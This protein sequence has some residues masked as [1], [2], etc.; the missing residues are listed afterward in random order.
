MA[1]GFMFWSAEVMVSR[2]KLTFSVSFR[3][4]T[5][6]HKTQNGRYKG[7]ALLFDFFLGA[8]NWSFS[9]EVF[10]PKNVSD[11]TITRNKWLK[12]RI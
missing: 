10:T 1:W 12:F 6:D 5:F 8:V 3:F 9:I 11:M 2:K 4:M 7:G